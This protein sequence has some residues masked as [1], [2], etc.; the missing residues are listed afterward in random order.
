MSLSKEGMPKGAVAA[1][2]GR[3]QGRKDSSKGESSKGE[4]WLQLGK[5]GKEAR[6]TAR[7]FFSLYR[8]S[9]REESESESEAASRM[10]PL[11]PHAGD[12]E[13]RGGKEKKKA[14]KGKAVY[15]DPW[16]MTNPDVQV[17]KKR[18][19]EPKK[20]EGETSGLWGALAK[21]RLDYD[22]Y[23]EERELNQKLQREHEQELEQKREQEQKRKQKLKLKLQLKQKQAKKRREHVV[24]YHE[25]EDGW[26][27]VS[28]GLD[29]WDFTEE[30][31]RVLPH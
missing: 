28:E 31:G 6:G 9:S 26:M 25:A 1:T 13:K 3:R 30:I 5:G 15:R 19:V 21:L 22:E 16:V 4:S 29:E 10:Q 8:E 18:E 12:D 17:E 23:Q 7:S 2:D 20:D 27:V 11:T 24:P 14:D